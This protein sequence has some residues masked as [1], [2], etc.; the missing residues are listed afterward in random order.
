MA[1]M[2][3]LQDAFPGGALNGSLWGSYGTLAVPSGILTLT[4]TADSTNYSGI[5]SSAAYDLTASYFAVQLVSAGSQF[6]TTQA[7]ILVMLNSTNTAELIVSDGSL[8]AQT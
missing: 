6:A 1:K 4:D 7:M 3:T 5:Q 2:S 8:D